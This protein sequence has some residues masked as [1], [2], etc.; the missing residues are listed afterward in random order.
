[1]DANRREGQ[2]TDREPLVTTG[3]ADDLTADDR[4]QDQPAQEGQQLVSGGRRARPLHD[5]VPERQ[6]DH[7]TEEA[8]HRGED[9]DH[10]DREASDAE[11]VERDH[12]LLRPRLYPYEQRQEG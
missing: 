12:R 7:R 8:E 2:S 3:A 1:Q 9:G 4:A 10:R 6:E 5:L 11:Q